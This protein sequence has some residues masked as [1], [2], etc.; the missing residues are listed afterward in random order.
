M[1]AHKLFAYGKLYL[2]ELWDLRR[3]ASLYSM[4]TRIRSLSILV[5]LFSPTA[6]VSRQCHRHVRI[7]RRLQT[8]HRLRTQ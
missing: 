6:S 3:I 7:G 5:T 1:I 8:G 4:Y 2:R